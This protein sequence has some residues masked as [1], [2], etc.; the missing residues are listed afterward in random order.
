[1]DATDCNLMTPLMRAAWNGYLECLLLLIQRGADVRHRRA[2]G[3]TA[4]HYAA[5][6][7]N[8]EV[9]RVL[10]ASGADLLPLAEGLSVVASACAVSQMDAASLALACGCRFALTCLDIESKNYYGF[11]CVVFGLSTVDCTL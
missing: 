10:F 11:K 1:M 9:L 6:R 3:C 2:N 4:A 5:H 7:G 8:V